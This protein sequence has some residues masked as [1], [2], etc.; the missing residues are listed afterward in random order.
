MQAKTNYIL[1]YGSMTGW[2]TGVQALKHWEYKSEVHSG[3]VI[4]KLPR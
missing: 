1:K 4:Q 2:G 3:E